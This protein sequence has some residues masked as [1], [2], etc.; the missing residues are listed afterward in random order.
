MLLLRYALLIDHTHRPGRAVN[1]HHLAGVFGPVLYKRT[2]KLNISDDDVS[3][4]LDSVL[5]DYEK[6]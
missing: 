2:F 4:A 6:P 1:L 3:E 5:R